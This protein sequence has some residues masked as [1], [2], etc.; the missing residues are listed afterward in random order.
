MAKETT[1][2]QATAKLIFM[3]YGS[4]GIKGGAILKASAENEKSAFMIGM[5]DGGDG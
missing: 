4:D 3:T 5:I 2:M 1:I